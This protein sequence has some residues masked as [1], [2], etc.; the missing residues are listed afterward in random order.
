MTLSTAPVVGAP[1]QEHWPQVFH[2]SLDAQT[3]FV[4]A[5][6]V[7]D[8]SKD[9]EKGRKFIDQLQA[10]PFDDVALLSDTLQKF[11]QDPSK[12]IQSFAAGL[13]VGDKAYLWSWNRGRIVLRR[14]EKKGTI[15]DSDLFKVVS[16]SVKSGDMYILGTESFFQ[17]VPV[18]DLLIGE[19]VED[20]ADQAVIA[21]QKAE[22]QAESAGYVLMSKGEVEPADDGE[23]NSIEPVTKIEKVP[24]QTSFPLSPVITTTTANHIGDAIHKIA[25]FMQTLHIPGNFMSKLEGVKINDGKSK[26]TRL[27]M[28]SIVAGT[29]LFLSILIV[30][31]YKAKQ[32]EKQISSML[33]PFQ[34]QLNEAKGSFSQNPADA[35]GKTSSLL[36]VLHEQNSRLKKKS[37]EQQQLLNFTKTVQEYYNSISGEKTLDSLPLFYN[38]QLVKSAFIAKHVALEGS[39]AVFVDP[40]GSAIQL[41]LNTK[42]P[43]VIDVGSVSTIQDVAIKDKVMYFLGSGADGLGIYA[44]GKL[45]SK[46]FTSSDNPI[47]LRLFGSAAY[48]YLK[49]AGELMKLI[50][51]NSIYGEP[52]AWLKT[53]QGLDRKSVTSMA[54]DGKVWLT[55]AKG[56]LFSF[57]QGSKQ[58]L[59][60]S[61]MLAPFSGSTVVYTTPDLQFLYILEPSQHR[62]VV[63]DKTGAYQKQFVSKDIG[64]TTD[65]IVSQDGKTAYLLAGSVVYSVSLE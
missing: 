58:S 45:V 20:F 25:T 5:F 55:T 40:E 38:F 57:A 14:A 21:L 11:S 1:N 10:L 43:S 33:Q 37:Y 49:D 27:I 44:G 30:S 59:K 53:S 6:C 15:V 42:Q 12:N 36:T 54:I 62:L 39:N 56:E 8:S 26:K 2:H 7:A 13:F 23:E 51:N 18:W 60:V 50:Q 9:R 16:G 29:L 63:L 52:K 34:Q 46:T 28:I 31:A 61:G 19:T 22:V 24:S 3:A 35:R 65:V 17:S 47:I 48:V 41:D 4:A 64:V 32:R